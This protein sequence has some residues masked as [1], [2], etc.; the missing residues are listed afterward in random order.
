[1]DLQGQRD[2]FP[3]SELNRDGG[4]LSAGVPPNLVSRLVW[5][6]SISSAWPARAPSR[7]RPFR[8]IESGISWR[9]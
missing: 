9:H 5:P 6:S 3:R 8:A 1:M 7:S 2:L 4:A